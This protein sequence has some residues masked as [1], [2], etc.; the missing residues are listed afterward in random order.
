MRKISGMIVLLFGILAAPVFGAAR[1]AVFPQFASGQGWS[2]E[3][4]FA[5]QGLTD[6]PG[7]V[8]YFYSSNGNPLTV[9]T[10]IGSGSSF[11][12]DLYA[13]YTKAIKIPAAAAYQVGYAIVKYPWTGDPIRATEVYRNEQNGA[14]GAE[15]G[16]P[17]QEQ[18]AHFSFPVEENSSDG[19][20]TALAIVNPQEFNPGESITGTIQATATRELGPG[21]HLPIYVN[22]IFPDI[23]DFT[24]TLS[25]SSPLGVG[26]LSLR[27]DREAFGAI[28]TDGGP[29]LKPFYVTG[30]IVTP[31]EPNDT[32]SQASV[33]AS[34]T[35][36]IQGSIGSSGDEDYYAFQGKAGDVL[37]IICDTSLNPNTTY[38]DSVLYLYDSTSEYPVAFNDQNGLA[39][40]LYP[41]NDSF[42]RIVLPKDDTYFLIVTDYWGSGSADYFNY[43]LYFKLN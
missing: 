29:I 20:H 18:G 5:N 22:Q 25:I 17:Q 35:I 2:S 21:Q 15:V 32:W 39:P 9:Q 3:F 7:I 10:S 1:Y 28:S 13:G 38:L 8:L 33:I 41:S 36:V 40:Q 23:G 12:F 42:I 16:V 26:V 30:N 31:S 24:G 27:Q 6:V 34:S 4:Y 37:S 11:A 43:K 19:I 14:V